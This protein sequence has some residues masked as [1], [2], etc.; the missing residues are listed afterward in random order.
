MKDYINLFHSIV[1]QKY[2]F[3]IILSLS[4]K[5]K[6]NYQCFYHDFE[7]KLMN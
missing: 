7:V 3:G 4:D 2:I 5:D 1:S 6:K